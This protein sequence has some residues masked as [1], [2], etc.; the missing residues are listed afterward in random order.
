MGKRPRLV[1][2]QSTKFC[3]SFFPPLL[4]NATKKDK[5]YTTSVAK[6]GK[7]AS[8]VLL[9]LTTGIKPFSSEAENVAPATAEVKPAIES[10]PAAEPK[11]EPKEEPG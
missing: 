6:D 11:S 2:S 5:L 9:G 10:K 1:C 3:L 7:S 8:L 4:L